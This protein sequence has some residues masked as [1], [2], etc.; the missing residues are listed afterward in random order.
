MEKK[1]ILQK[2]EEV[3]KTNFLNNKDIG[4]TNIKSLSAMVLNAD[5]YEEIE[6]FI[7]YKTGKGNGW[8]KT[9]P[10]SKQKFGDFIINKIREIKNVS[11]D[12]KEAIKNISLFF[13]YLYWL[14][15]GLEG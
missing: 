10:N 4:S 12:D 3:R 14:K 11:K 13:G 9:L 8:E 2:V 1:Q 15:R 7:K 5:C 6:L